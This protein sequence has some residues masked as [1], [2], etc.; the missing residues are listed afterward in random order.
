MPTVFLDSFAIVTQRVVSPCVVRHLAT[1]ASVQPMWNALR[2]FVPKG[3]AATR[4]VRDSVNRVAMQAVWVCVRPQQEHRWALVQR[5]PILVLPVV[6]PATDRIVRNVRFLQPPFRVLRLRVQAV[7]LSPKR[8]A[9]E[10]GRARRRV[11]R[12]ATRLSVA[13]RAVLVRV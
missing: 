9:T 2:E 13:Q 4:D 11:A 8:F 1:D 10:Q 6:V 7:L 3:C 5:A 12:N